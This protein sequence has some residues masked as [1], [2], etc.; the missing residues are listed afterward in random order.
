MICRPG[1]TCSSASTW[2]SDRA[3]SSALSSTSPW[4]LRVNVRK[5]PCGVRSAVQRRP[6]SVLTMWKSVSVSV[7]ELKAPAA[8]CSATSR[9][10]SRTCPPAGTASIGS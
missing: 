8:F 3:V 5:T 7:G 6:S 2:R 9:G 1:A 10:T 4:L